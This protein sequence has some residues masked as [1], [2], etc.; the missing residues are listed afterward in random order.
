[1]SQE[2]KLDKF[3]K[4]VS[5]TPSNFIQ[6]LNEYRAKKTETTKEFNCFNV[7]F[8]DN[9]KRC[10]IQCELCKPKNI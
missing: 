1:M 10:I 5:D 6:K 4:L 7:T 8:S 3:E 9:P 2:E